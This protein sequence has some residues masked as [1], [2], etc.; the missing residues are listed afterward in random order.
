MRRQPKDPSLNSIHPTKVNL[1][2]T[3]GDI[4]RADV[5]FLLK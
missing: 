1:L 3:K 4:N 5:K 2:T